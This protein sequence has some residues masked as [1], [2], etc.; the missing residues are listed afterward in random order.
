[1]LYLRKCSEAFDPAITFN[2]AGVPLP[3]PAGL[4]M[5]SVWADESAYALPSA[6]HNKHFDIF[7]DSHPYLEETFPA[8]DI[9]PSNPPRSNVYCDAPVVHHPMVSPCTARSWKGAPP[10]WFAMGQERILDAAKIVAQTAARDGVPVLW[11]EYERMP[12]CWI[13]FVPRM[14]HTTHCYRAWGEACR[15]LGE[16][17][18]FRTRG[19]M[20][21]ID[22]L[23][24]TEVDTRNLISLS[25]EEAESRIRGKALQMKSWVGKRRG[26]PSL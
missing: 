11:N 15:K 20:I 14:P 17:Q 8:D 7:E 25:P 26:G 5:L 6:E 22:S 18:E 24:E 9:W 21:Y 16:G 23:K 13:S 1:M 3:L 19:R 10:M 2:G 4:A 12:H